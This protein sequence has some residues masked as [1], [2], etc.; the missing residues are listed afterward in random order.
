MFTEKD[1]EKY[2]VGYYGPRHDLRYPHIKGKI[3]EV[4]KP[5]E[6][7]PDAEGKPS[8]DYQHLFPPTCVQ[9]ITRRS[10]WPLATIPNERPARMAAS[11]ALALCLAAIA[12][13]SEIRKIASRN[14]LRSAGATIFRLPF[15]VLG[16]AA[17]EATIW[18]NKKGPYGD[19]EELML[20]QLGRPPEA[21][22]NP[23][24][25]KNGKLYY[26]GK[27]CAKRKPPKEQK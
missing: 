4:I 11:V 23:Y 2:G 16:G 17:Q 22:P 5:T 12:T 20:H 18:P 26:R 21:G 24:R 9:R 8:V 13:P 6:P 1:Q 19:G 25:W 3:P 27:P 14:G 15:S 7:H 10:R